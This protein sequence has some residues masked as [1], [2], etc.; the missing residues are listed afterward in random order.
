MDN[1][2][3]ILRL[4]MQMSATNILIYVYCVD[5][6]SIFHYKINT[7]IPTIFSI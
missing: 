3:H 2:K 4:K 6:L 1:I 5:F 7:I